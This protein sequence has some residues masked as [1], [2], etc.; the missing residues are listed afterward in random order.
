MRLTLNLFW[1]TSSYLY[2]RCNWYLP[3]ATWYQ[4]NLCGTS[5]RK[6]IMLIILTN[7]PRKYRLSIH[8]IEIWLFHYHTTIVVITYIKLVG[9]KFFVV[10]KPLSFHFQPRH[11]PLYS[12]YMQCLFYV[13]ML[14]SH[15]KLYVIPSCLAHCGSLP[16]I[17]LCLYSG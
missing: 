3:S 11:R 1:Q 12:L 15:L 7:V 17:M 8:L 2:R 9:Q 16:T 10:T 14:C 5:W 13:W 6:I 4:F